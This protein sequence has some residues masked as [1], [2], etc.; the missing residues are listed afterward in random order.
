MYDD[1]TTAVRWW[2]FPRYGLSAGGGIRADRWEVG[3]HGTLLMPR[4]VDYVELGLGIRA[5]YHF[6]EF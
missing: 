3:L 2:E 1:K 6:T 5:A 4:L